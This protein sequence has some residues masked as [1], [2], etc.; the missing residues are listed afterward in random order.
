[1]SQQPPNLPQPQPY[2]G[3]PMQPGMYPPPQQPPKK[4][5]TRRNAIIAVV[6]VVV[7][8]AACGGIAAAI[9]NAG[10]SANSGTVVNNTSSTSTTGNT[11]ATSAP[12][13]FKV[14][15]VVSVGNTWQITVLS[16]KTDA[17]GQFNTLQKAGDVFLIIQVSVK[18]I[19]SQSQTMSS[20]LQ[21][22][23]QDSTGQKYT[24]GIDTNAGSTLDG[25]V[26]VGMPLKGALTYEVPKTVKIFTLS[27]QNDITSSD[28][29]IWDITL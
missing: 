10:K 19:S 21:W 24:I 15:Q 12:T 1:M 26:A 17:G 28:Q 11:Q 23:L 4:K 18:N 6:V 16:A 5:H 3:Q 14:G 20:L 22:N 25:A 7:L 2:Q 27:F 29:S 13:T 9:S 8:L